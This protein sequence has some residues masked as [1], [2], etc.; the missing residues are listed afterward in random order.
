MS[1]EVEPKNWWASKTIWANF[2]AI[3]A[4]LLASVGL[5]LDVG[6]VEIVVITVVNIALRFLTKSPVQV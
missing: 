4:V 5:D 1:V 6:T 3:I 2:A